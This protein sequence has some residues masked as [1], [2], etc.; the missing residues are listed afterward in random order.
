MAL[1]ST[2][3]KQGSWVLIILIALGLGGF[4]IQDMFSGGPSQ[5]L[6]GQAPLGKING[7]KLDINEFNRTESILYSGSAGDIYSRRNSL[8]NYYIEK[9]LVEEESQALGLGV[10]KT[11]LNDL[12][13]GPQPSPVIAQRFMDPNTGQLNFQQLSQ[14]RSQIQSGQFTDPNIRAYWRIQETEIVKERLQSKLTSMVTKGLYTPKWMAEIGHADQTQSFEVEL[15][16]IPFD[17]V[18]NSEV[19]LV[20][21]DYQNYIDQR[22]SVYKRDEETRRLDYVVFNVAPTSADSVAIREDLSQLKEEFIVA[23]NDTNFVQRNQGVLNSNYLKAEQVSPVITDVLTTSS[24]GTVYGP[25]LESGSFNLVKLIDRKIIPDSVESRHILMRAQSQE[26]LVTNMGKIDSIKTALEEGGE[27]WDAMNEKYNQDI[28]AKAQ[29]GDLGYVAQD[30]MVKPFNDLIFFDAEIGELKTVITQFGIHLVEVTGKKFETNEEGFRLAFINR[31]IVPSEETQKARFDDALTFLSEQDN[32]ASMTQAADAA[33]GLNIITAG[34]VQ[35]ND[36]IVS[37]LGTGQASRDMI[38]WAFD[39]KPGDI[40][41]EI[42]VYTDD[43]L[44]FDNKYVIAALKTIQKPGMPKL[45]EIR[46]DIEQLVMNQKKGELLAK[47]AVGK[48]LQNLAEEFDV[49]I[50]TALNLTFNTSFVPN[51]GDEPKLLGALVNLEQGEMTQPIVGNS[52]VFVARVVKKSIPSAITNYAQLRQQLSSS[53]RSQVGG[54]LMEAMR[55]D[56]K[57]VDNRSVYY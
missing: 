52:G 9:V 11:E 7:E 48:D 3:R 28:A 24:V 57:I 10:G 15:V 16:R 18:D 34:P 42:Y 40:S 39:A 49:S 43:Q 36:F 6:G 29:G 46:S 1:I 12:Q 35:E 38:R 31:N 20:D 17:E 8:W 23:D 47:Q 25:Y 14:I 21:G 51:L 41:S 53:I 45:D 50:D 5:S 30:A 22:A 33:S 19:G 54:Q 4:I 26:E 32:L 37:A 13:F 55:A 56:A 44:Y 27:T 2:I